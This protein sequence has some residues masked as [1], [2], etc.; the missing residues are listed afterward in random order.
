MPM[1]S[2]IKQA[3]AGFSRHA[4]ERSKEAV[5]FVK[6]SLAVF[7]LVWLT[8]TALAALAR[9]A[10]SPTPAVSFL[11]HLQLIIP[12]ALVS[13]APIAGFLLGRAAF[14]GRQ[15]R[16]S[17]SYRFAF[18]GT[19]RNI[20]PVKA[21]R[22]PSFGAIGFMASLTIGMMLNVVMRTGEYFLAIP[23]LTSAAPDWGVT[24][25]WI[26]TLS[27]VVMNFFYMVCFAMALRKVPLF[28]KMLLF[29]WMLDIMLQLGIANIIGGSGAPADVNAALASLLNGNINK[30][31]ISAAIWLPYLI[32][33]ERV[34]VTFRHRVA[35]Q[36][37]VSQSG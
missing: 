15:A 8:C 26:A 31:L 32:L 27:T 6:R 20:S 12:Y 2:H 23:A 7:A 21:A 17:T 10:L 24:L 25:F 11:Q 29:V 14:K 22:H 36:S 37:N 1:R 4:V 9:I 16:S 33:S 35:A 18:V 34:N 13:I 30:V 5:A 19:W 28:P 3:F